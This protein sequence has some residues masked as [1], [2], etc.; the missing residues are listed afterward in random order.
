VPAKHGQ[1]RSQA[2]ARGNAAEH[3]DGTVGEDERTH[4]SARRTAEVD[5]RGVQR[6]TDGSKVRGEG[7]QPRL[8]RRG[9]PAVQAKTIR[10]AAIRFAARYGVFWSAKSRNKISAITPVFDEASTCVIVPVVSMYRCRSV[11]I[12]CSIH[13]WVCDCVAPPGAAAGL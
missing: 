11:G 3:P 8:P 13:R 2:E 10:S 1:Q 5:R 4:R 9:V 12:A 7:D 6:E